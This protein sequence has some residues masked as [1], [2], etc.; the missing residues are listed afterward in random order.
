MANKANKSK[1]NSKSNKT[2]HVLNLLT[3]ST[4]PSETGAAARQSQPPA[5][6]PAP[7]APAVDNEAVSE[8]I[9]SALEEELL[10]QLEAEEAAAPAPQPE[11]VPEP[12]PQ[13]EMEPIPEPE[14]EFIPAVFEQMEAP[15]PASI[16]EPDPESI[17]VP[18]PMPDH[19]PEAFPEPQPMPEPEPEAIPEPQP[20]PEPEEEA[21]PM[22]RVTYLN[23][24][25]ALVENKVD[26]YMRLH[27]M[28][29]CPR[30]R[31]DVVALTLTSLPAK[32]I[33]IPENEGVPMLTLYE[34][35]YSTAVSA[36]LMSA[37]QKVAAHPRHTPNADGSLRLGA[38]RRDD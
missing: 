19:D 6:V 8:N 35:R 18:Q 37:C 33:V 11:P 32:Y 27:G 34:N 4:G 1:G 25:Q 17:P 2:A 3:D 28:C 12:E 30:C 24:M 29:A 38:P 20:E 13:V 9:R 16:P 21:N 15:V 31:T 14:P 5:P 7:A 23:I 26:D 36:Q 22:E 10:A